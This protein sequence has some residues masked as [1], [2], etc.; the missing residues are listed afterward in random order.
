MHPFTLVDLALQNLSERR[1]SIAVVCGDESLTYGELA[2][3]AEYYARRLIGIGVRKRD[4]VC[5]HVPKS[6]NEVVYTVAI[7]MAGAIVVNVNS[8]V[9]PKMLAHA[10]EN[11]DATVLIASHRKLLA[12]SKLTRPS[13]LRQYYRG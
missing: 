1:D 7:S 9:T 13:T 5:L 6:I 11:S 3:Q 12:L 2:V 4:S 8:Q 10:I